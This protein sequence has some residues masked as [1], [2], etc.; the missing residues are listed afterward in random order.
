M[1]VAQKAE[2]ER[3]RETAARAEAR[4]Q[5]RVAQQRAQLEEQAQQEALQV[6]GCGC[7]YEA[8]CPECEYAPF[9]LSR[10]CFSF[11]GMESVFFSV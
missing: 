1:A 11:R 5:E 10:E 8:L 3:E 7:V 6:A 4:E 9:L 2:R